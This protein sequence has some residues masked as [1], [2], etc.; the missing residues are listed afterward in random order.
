MCQFPKAD[1]LYTGLI[2]DISIMFILSRRLSGDQKRNLMRKYGSFGMLLGAIALGL[3]LALSA[4]LSSEP[5]KHLSSTL[6]IGKKIILGTECW[7]R[8]DYPHISTHVP[9]T[10]NVIAETACPGGSVSIR[11]TL[12]RAKWMFFRES[13]SITKTDLNSVRVN[14]ALNCKWKVGD[15]PI[16][17]FVVSVHQD[18][19]GASGVTNLK[20]SLRC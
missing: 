10:V 19:T 15:P 17:Y 3:P 1:S 2:P 9:R 8:T 12:W 7:G 18:N 5:S 13:I 11:T 16:E 6:R 20:R 4:S 14:V